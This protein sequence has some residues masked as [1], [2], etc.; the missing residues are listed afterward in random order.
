MGCPDWANTQGSAPYNVTGVPRQKNMAQMKEQI[1]APKIE[2]SSEEIAN[3][4]D[5]EFK[6]PVVRVLTEM[7]S[8][9]TKHEKVKAM[10]SEI[11]KNRLGPW[12]V[13]LSEL[14]ASL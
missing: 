13:W 4:S 14:S 8:M 9:V 1:K 12:L 2:L 10:K 5:A 7:G 6:T 3:L 11:K